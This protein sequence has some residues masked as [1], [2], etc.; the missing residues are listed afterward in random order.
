MPLYI[1]NTHVYYF[2]KSQDFVKAIK[3][4]F[5]MIYMTLDDFTIQG[6]ITKARSPQGLREIVSVHGCFSHLTS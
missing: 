4:I 2:G 3:N 6:K 5:I 1:K